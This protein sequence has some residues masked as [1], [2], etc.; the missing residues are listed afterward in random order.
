M[1]LLVKPGARN[2]KSQ[3]TVRTPKVSHKRL[4]VQD[5]KKDKEEETLNPKVSL[6]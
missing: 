3:L 1:R 2:I 4:I 6:K 5:V